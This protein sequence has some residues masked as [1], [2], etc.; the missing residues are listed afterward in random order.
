MIV[1]YWLS[2]EF[3]GAVYDL[4]KELT[5][6]VGR[7]DIGSGTLLTKPPVSDIQWEFKQKAALDRAV[8]R[9][10]MA[11]WKTPIRVSVGKWNG[12]EWEK[13]KQLFQYGKFKNLNGFKK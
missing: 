3:E 13:T 8:I 2:V 5:R 6:I 1:K 7:T 4:R 10:N 11:K 9:L 12:L